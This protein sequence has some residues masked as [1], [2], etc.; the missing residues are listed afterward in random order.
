MLSRACLRLTAG[1]RWCPSAAEGVPCRG[2]FFTASWPDGKS[3]DACTT[4]LSDEDA[5]RRYA[6]LVIRELKARPDYRD[7]QTMVVR[8]DNGDVIHTISF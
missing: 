5:A 8:D 6:H 7:A 3:G 4:S 1:H 2:I